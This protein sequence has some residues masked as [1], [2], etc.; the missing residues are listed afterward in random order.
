[1]SV[2]V[3]GD[4]VSDDELS[5]TFSGS[6][7]VSGCLQ[8]L[9]NIVYKAEP[10]NCYP[11]PCGIGAFYQPSIDGSV[12]FYTFGGFRYEIEAIGAIADTVYVPK[13]GFEKAAVF[14]SK[15]CITQLLD[16]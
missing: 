1:M 13:I 2:A 14:C 7:D 4:T 6:G 12:T 5:I 8:L 9:N 16:L 10:S 3:V 15:A 11:K